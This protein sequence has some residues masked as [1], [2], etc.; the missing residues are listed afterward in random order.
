MFQFAPFVQHLCLQ[1]LRRPRFVGV[2]VDLLQQR[3]HDGG[4]RHRVEFA[5]HPER[6]QGPVWVVGQTRA[7]ELFHGVRF[8]A[9]RRDQD[10]RFAAGTLRADSVQ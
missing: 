9:L 5:P 6:P 1:H 8:F 10:Q 2:G 7:A 3:A 4:Q